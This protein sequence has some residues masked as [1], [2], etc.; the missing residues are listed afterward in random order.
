MQPKEQPIYGLQVQ[1]KP[2]RWIYPVAGLKIDR[3]MMLSISGRR[4]WRQQ[5]LD[6]FEHLVPRF[7]Q[8]GLDH[9]SG[10]RGVAATA[11]PF[12]D[13]PYIDAAPGTE[14][15]FDPALRLFHE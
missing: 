2:P 12:G 7:L 14:T 11:K 15:D 5:F 9:G 10:S 4:Q 6:G 1:A 13:T 3:E 8:G